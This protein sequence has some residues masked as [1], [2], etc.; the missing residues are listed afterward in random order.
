M[1]RRRIAVPMRLEFTAEAAW[2]QSIAEICCL[3]R[4]MTWTEFLQQRVLKIHMTVRLLLQ[5]KP[6]GKKALENQTMTAYELHLWVPLKLLPMLM[7][8]KVFLMR[9]YGCF[10]LLTQSIFWTPFSQIFVRNRLRFCRKRCITIYLNR[11]AKFYIE[12]SD[13]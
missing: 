5:L 2:H 7:V 1:E 12:A 10:K 4:R 8:L 3:R 6:L 11:Y 9:N 13:N